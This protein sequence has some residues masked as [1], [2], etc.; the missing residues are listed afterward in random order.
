MIV[1][2]LLLEEYNFVQRYLFH[3][4]K[5]K[6]SYIHPYFRSGIYKVIF[7]HGSSS[8]SQRYLLLEQKTKYTVYVI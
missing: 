4:Y 7:N 5:M 3:C 1:S 8:I 2:E 6:Y